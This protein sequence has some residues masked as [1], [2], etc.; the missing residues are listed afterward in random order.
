M[1]CASSECSAR[2]IKLLSRIKRKHRR[3]KLFSFVARA[4]E[5]RQPCLRRRS[6]KEEKLQI[7]IRPIKAPTSV[8]AC[9][10]IYCRKLSQIRYAKKLFPGRSV[11]QIR[12]CRK[13]IK[14]LVVTAS[15]LSA[16][17]IFRQ[18]FTLPWQCNS[19]NGNGSANTHTAAVIKPIQP[20]T[21]ARLGSNALCKSHQSTLFRGLSQNQFSFLTSPQKLQID[22]FTVDFTQKTAFS[23]T[24]ADE[25]K[26]KKNFHSLCKSPIGSFCLWF[27]Q[28]LRS[29]FECLSLCA[30]IMS[31]TEKEG[32]I[33]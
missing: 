11:C 14:S 4:E 26:A 32:K 18:F 2:G 19:S 7:Q 10:M 6:R 9:I 15:A 21:I 30:G 23:V 12:R 5:S 24:N 33:H 8:S 20:D 29:D 16:T 25:R 28:L 17:W 31:R 22:T 1:S 13:L 27:H 3:R